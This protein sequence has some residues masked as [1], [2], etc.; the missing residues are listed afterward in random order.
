MVIVFLCLG[1]LIVLASYPAFSGSPSAGSM[2]ALQ[3]TKSGQTT[4]SVSKG[5]RPDS[6]F[7]ITQAT[8]TATVTNNATMTA[9]GCPSAPCNVVNNYF[10][11]QLNIKFPN[12]NDWIQNGVSSPGGSNCFA[13]SFLY[14][15][16]IPGVTQSISCS[17]AFSTA[18]YFAWTVSFSGGYLQ[19]I[20]FALDGQSVYSATSMTL[21]G[22]S[23]CVSSTDSYFQSVYVG[24]VSPTYTYANFTSGYGKMSY[25]GVNP[26]VCNFPSCVYTVTAESSN[27]QYGQPFGSGSSWSQYFYVT[28]AMV[29]SIT[30]HGSLG[31]T[32]FTLRLSQNVMKGDLIVAA[33]G[34]YAGSV[35][36]GV[37][38][39]QGNSWQVAKRLSTSGDTVEIFY[40]TAKTTSSDTV[41]ITTSSTATYTYGFVIEYTGSTINLDQVSSGSGT[42]T[43]PQVQSFTPSTGTVVVDIAAGP[44]GWRPGTYYTMVGNNPLWSAA[45]EFEVYWNHGSTTAS[46]TD[47]SGGTY[48]EVAASFS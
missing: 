48:A 28:W 26:T 29:Q 25:S 19:S 37:S 23:N 7:N 40:A 46:W 44:S 5:K 15:S 2:N 14:G 17:Q 8:V 35:S 32:S 34:T 30:G 43:T 18:T 47:Q 13:T 24:Y 31:G 3:A 21:V 27:M 1:F 12:Q 16:S 4:M 22:C 10:S 39:S 9:A 20:S 41:T 42:G 6:L 36:L 33:V 11:Y 45:S 38:D